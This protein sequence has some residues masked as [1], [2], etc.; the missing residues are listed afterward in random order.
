MVEVI[1]SQINIVGK[2]VKLHTLHTL[3]NNIT[4][5]IS[6]IARHFR[7]STIKKLGI[8]VSVYII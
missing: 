6:I 3:A 1:L 2:C 5:L 8:F 4:I 7:N